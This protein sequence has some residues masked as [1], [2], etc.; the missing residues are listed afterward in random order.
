MSTAASAIGG[1]VKDTTNA[2]AIASAGSSAVSNSV[3]LGKT[4][5]TEAKDA[6]QVMATGTMSQKVAE[7]EK[8]G[9]EVA[10]DAGIVAK[11]LEQVLPAP[12]AN[13]ITEATAEASKVGSELSQAKTAF[14]QATTI[15]QKL[16]V[17]EKVGG[18]LVTEAKDIIPAVTKAFSSG[19][20]IVQAGSE[21]LSSLSTIVNTLEHGT[22]EEKIDAIEGV[23]GKVV[24]G[25]GLIVS[26]LVHHHESAEVSVSGAPATVT[27]A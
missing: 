26:D 11:D 12:I 22:I 1:V 21:T 23:A 10:A 19:G 8:I 24:G 13:L 4:I 7:V 3:A 2:A 5:E 6:E 16:T 17:V 15:E 20:E 25:I 14:S 9:S 18:E 27:E